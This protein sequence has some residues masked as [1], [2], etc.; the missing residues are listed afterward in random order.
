MEP[1]LSNRE[2]LAVSSVVHLGDTGNIIFDLMQS[3][4]DGSL[5]SFINSLPLF[6]EAG[7]DML[8]NL[9]TGIVAALPEL[10]KA[11]PTSELRR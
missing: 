9:I 7:I 11:I 1:L 4:A 5:G 6:V 8:K 10:M 2:L 3:I